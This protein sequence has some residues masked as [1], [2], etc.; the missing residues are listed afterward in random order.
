MPLQF[1]NFDVFSLINAM[2]SPG[3]ANKHNLSVSLNLIY[4][5]SVPLTSHLSLTLL[6]DCHGVVLSWGTCDIHLERCE[7]KVPSAWDTFPR[8][9]LEVNTVCVLERFAVVHCY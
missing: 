5:F 8:S 3:M 9:A 4:P 2:F 7:W 1:L 6:G